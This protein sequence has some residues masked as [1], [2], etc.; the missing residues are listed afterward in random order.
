[1]LFSWGDHVGV[2]DQPERCFV[3]VNVEY[4]FER[5]KC[6]VELPFKAL[7]LIFKPRMALLST[8]AYPLVYGWCKELNKWLIFNSLHSHL[9]SLRLN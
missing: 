4:C 5:P 3:Y 8:S 1:M 6:I 9:I 7:T 2:V